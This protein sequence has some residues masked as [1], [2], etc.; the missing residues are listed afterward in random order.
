MVPE[1]VVED[2]IAQI[3]I[4][5]AAIA[6]PQHAVSGNDEVSTNAEGNHFNRDVILTIKNSA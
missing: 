2:S 4:T 6:T 3:A 1:A 5:S